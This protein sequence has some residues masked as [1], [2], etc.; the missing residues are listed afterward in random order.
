V[1]LVT[2]YIVSYCEMAFSLSACVGIHCCVMVPCCRVLIITAGA[3]REI[4]LV[5]TVAGHWSLLGLVC[6]PVRGPHRMSM[7]GPSIVFELSI[8]CE[9]WCECSS[10][11]M[12]SPLVQVG[13]PWLSL[14]GIC[15]IRSCSRSRHDSWEELVACS[16]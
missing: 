10:A 13:G 5:C 3:I 9:L 14:A 16:G 1:Q 11:H 12:F 6:T 8:S 15:I 2:C 7:A 4:H